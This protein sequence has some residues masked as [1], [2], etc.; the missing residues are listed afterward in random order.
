M[1]VSKKT[2]RALVAGFALSLGFTLTTLNPAVAFSQGISTGVL[3]GT[4]TDQT[5]AVLPDVTIKVTNETTGAVSIQRSRPDGGFSLF[6]LPIGRY[7][8]MFSVPSFADTALKNVPVEVGVRRDL[9]SIV[10][11]PSGEQTTVEVSASTDELLIT[12]TA[13]VSTTFQPDQIANLPLNNGFDAVT[14]LLPGVVRT[15]DNS[16]SNNAGASFSVNGQ[17]GRSN[18]FEIDGQSNN[19][20]SVAGPQVFFGNQDAIAG[21]QVITNDFGAQYG[22]NMGGVVNYLTKSGTNQIHGTVFEF[23]EGNWGEAFL[24]GQKSI[25]SGYCAPGQSE[26]DG[27]LV[28]TLAR[29]VENRFGGTIGAPI[30]K[31]KLWGFAGIYFDRNHQG[32]GTYTTG[33]SSLFPTPDSLTALSAVGAGNGGVASLVNSGPY[34]VTTGNPQP[35]S[36]VATRNLTVNSTTVAVDYAPVIRQ[37]TGQYNDEELMGRLDWQPTAKDHLFVRYIYQDAPYTGAYADSTTSDLAVGRWYDVP[38]TTHSI[39]GDFTH[40][41]SPS[42]VNQIRY[43]FQQSNVL[44]QGGGQPDCTVNTPTNCNAPISLG[45]GYQ[46]YGYSSSM[47]QG[48]IVKVT[49]V[50]DNATW[51]RGHHSISFGGEWSYQNSPNFFLPYYNGSFSSSTP[52][53]F[54]DGIGTLNIADGSYTIH[55]TEPDAAAY[56]QDD[57]KI[58]QDFTLNLGLRWEFFGQAIN[59][60]HDQTAKREADDSTAFWDTSLDLSERTF[61][62]VPNN[63]KNFQP[64]IGFAY[65]PSFAQRFVVRGGFAINFD[66]QF[67][68]MF[69]N[70]ATA[71][72]V[73]NLGTVSCVTATNCLP[74]SGTTGADFRAQD[75]SLIPRGVNPNTRNQTTVSS[76]F[77]NPYTESYNLGVQWGPN[78]NVV[79]EVRYTGNHAVGLFQSLNANPYM[80]DVAEAYPGVISPSQFCTDTSAIG[81]GRLDCNKT[82][83][84]ERANTAFS[85]Y[86]GLQLNATTRNYHH[87]TGTFAYT[88]SRTIDN[89]SEVFGTLAGGST[90]AFAQNPFDTNLGERGVSGISI[91]HVLSASFNYDLPIFAHQNGLFGKLLGG[92]HFSGIWSYDTGQPVTPFQYGIY[93]YYQKYYGYYPGTQS[94]CDI[95]FASSFNSTVS[96]CRPV[97][98]NKKAPANS[99]GIYVNNENA[100]AVGIASGYYTL[101]SFLDYENGDTDGNGDYIEPVATTADSVRWLYN[102]TDLADLLGN[103][104]PGSGRGLLRANKWNNV[105][106][107]VSKDTKI[108]EHYTLEL[109]FSAYNVLNH[110][111][112]GTPDPE[113]DDVLYGSETFWDNNYNYG[114]NARQVQIGARIHF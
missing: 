46:S 56:I 77:H 22:R 106:A 55:F 44:F 97:L 54:L 31:N 87:M 64:R 59:L 58:G 84:R 61:A 49:Q 13:Q 113:I 99:V 9:G 5:G 34:S 37:V 110:R 18:N 114:S 103:P 51:I 73:V 4:A 27:C 63:F 102:N 24:Q 96:T 16:F 43:S 86:N 67:Y 25:Y 28:P 109:M 105:D 3:T 52:Q 92:Y 107:T 21:L 68:N 60:L 38:A 33:T 82:K 88:Y 90:V 1:T 76:N 95:N 81:Y 50:Q 42:W 74:A 108:K 94:Y 35:G 53:R 11:K 32:A 17:R 40:T 112:L 15:H 98:S 100:D 104:F 83:V 30:I 23:Y 7:T 14:L 20:N 66:P 26:S 79:F 8:I 85:I 111:L 6:N 29:F 2:L 72:P 101:G 45:T 12:T 41:F 71:S 75:L 78:N 91:P 70:S 62:S 47:P 93:D 36:V 89:A 19:D 69:L 48:R 10:M 80:L 39:G 57:W 65:A